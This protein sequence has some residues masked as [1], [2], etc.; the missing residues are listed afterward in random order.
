MRVCDVDY[1]TDY[2]KVCTF[3]FLFPRL[4]NFTLHE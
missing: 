1:R 2:L 4:N 3:V